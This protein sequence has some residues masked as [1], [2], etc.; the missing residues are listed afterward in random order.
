MNPNLIRESLQKHVGERVKVKIY[1]MRNKTD[2]FIGTL[3]DIYPQI[4][5]VEIESVVTSFSYSE[6]ISGEVVVTFV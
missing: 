5:T 2:T 6:V 4:F 1:G 3:K